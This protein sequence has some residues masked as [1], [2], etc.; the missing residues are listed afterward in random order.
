MIMT[1]EMIDVVK[2]RRAAVLI[3]K[4]KIA[5]KNNDSKKIKELKRELRKLGMSHI[6]AR[7]MGPKRF[8]QAVFLINRQNKR[9]EG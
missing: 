8:E 2:R 4:L 7:L 9:T 3:G 5:Q 1:T 6:V